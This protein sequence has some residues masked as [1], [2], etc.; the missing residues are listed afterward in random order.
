MCLGVISRSGRPGL[1]G[2]SW[3]LGCR[4][5]RVLLLMDHRVVL[6]GVLPRGTGPFPVNQQTVGIILY[7][8]VIGQVV[9]L[10]AWH[11]KLRGAWGTARAGLGIRENRVDEG[12]IVLVLLML[13]GPCSKGLLV[14]V[15]A[16]DLLLMLLLAPLL[17]LLEFFHV[18]VSVEFNSCG[19]AS[20]HFLF[21]S[22]I[23]NSHSA[24]CLFLSSLLE[25]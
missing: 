11:R 7:H 25:I 24:L 22:W 10:E 23:W 17:L 4:C 15:M 5:V 12:R 19:C 2:N 3:G 8:V 21:V 20:D 14:M 13:L 6:L 16:Q 9:R 1:H 18:W